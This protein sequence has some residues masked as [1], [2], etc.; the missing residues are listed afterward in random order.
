MNY[1]RFSLFQ[2]MI[3]QFESGVLN[4]LVPA[5]LL[6]FL[7]SW[8]VRSEETKPQFLKGRQGFSHHVHHFTPTEQR[9]LMAA[10]WATH[11]HRA[12]KPAWAR[13]LCKGNK[14]YRYT[15]T[16]WWPLEIV[17]GLTGKDIGGN[18][19]KPLGN[20]N[21]TEGKSNA[22]H[23]AACNRAERFYSSQLQGRSHSCCVLQLSLL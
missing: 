6:T 20:S 11:K 8:Y 22:R 21:R 10:P 1:F 5:F 4:L 2:R 23:K 9:Y 12:H 15:E 19:I 16:Y 14:C 17:G 3:R 18:S 13:K 7:R